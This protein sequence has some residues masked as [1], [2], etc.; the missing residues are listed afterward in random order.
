MISIKVKFKQNKICSLQRQVS[1]DFATY[2]CIK[3]LNM[4][5]NKT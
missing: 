2:S 1:S 5:K 4:T 3:Y